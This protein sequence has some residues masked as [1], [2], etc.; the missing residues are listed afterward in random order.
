MLHEL[1]NSL[2]GVLPKAM[3]MIEEEVGLELRQE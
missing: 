3:L 2:P 1:K